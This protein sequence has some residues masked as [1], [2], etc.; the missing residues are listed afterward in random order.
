MAIGA[1]LLLLFMTLGLGKRRICE[2]TGTSH[3]VQAMN[4]IGPDV[5]VCLSTN[6]LRLPNNRDVPLACIYPLVLQGIT[7]CFCVVQ[8]GNN[9]FH[10]LRT[11]VREQKEKNK[12]VNQLT[13]FIDLLRRRK[14]NKSQKKQRRI[15]WGDIDRLRTMYNA[16][17]ASV[18]VLRQGRNRLIEFCLRFCLANAYINSNTAEGENDVFVSSFEADPR[19]LLSSQALA[20]VV[21]AVVVASTFSSA[22]GKSLKKTDAAVDFCVR[23]VD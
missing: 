8:D 3:E 1:P 21:V 16:S 5:V 15:Q 17:G 4:N 14:E 22:C 2:Q 18:S 23:Q 9:S 11:D 12:H 13:S 10:R 19:D 7:S 20:V 6:S